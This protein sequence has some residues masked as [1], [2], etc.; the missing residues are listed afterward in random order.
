[1]FR[2]DTVEITGFW[3]NQTA[4]ARFFPDV[5]IFIGRNGTG[6]TTFMDLLHGVLTVDL[7]VLASH[8]F[9]S[10]SIRM[11]AGS[12]T[13]ILRVSKEQGQGPVELLRFQVGKN[14]YRFP[15]YSPE[16]DVHRHLRARP[17]LQAQFRTL[18]VALSKLVNVSSLPVDRS[19]HDSFSEDDYSPSRRPL[20]PQVDERLT[21]LS[22]QFTQYQLALASEA[23]GINEHFQNEVL[24]SIL[25]DPRFDSFATSNL[26]EID[27][28]HHE[29][30]LNKAYSE[31][32]A[33]TAEMPDRITKH[34]RAIERSLSAVRAFREDNAGIAIDDI[35]PIAL[36][37]RSTHIVQLLSDAEAQRNRVFR[38]ID[39]FLKTLR[40]FIS[41]KHLEVSLGGDLQFARGNREL[42]ISQLSSG[43]KQLLILLTETLLQR[44]QPFVFIADEPELSLHIEWQAQVV[45]SIKHLNE[46]AQVIVATHSPE[47][48]AGWRDR[49]IQMEE[50][51][52]G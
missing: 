42:S 8:E 15:L 47:I 23:E 5:S 37:R 13:R 52:S 20:R 1:M 12:R 6:K 43:E 50:V 29:E 27:L 45:K 44:S 9:D 30:E 24:A 40:S 26:K 3:G 21:D 31:L 19:A 49:I 7:R 41:D 48:A 18:K 38:P 25:Y 4:K 46:N 10:I 11:V 33:F 39:T 36:L 28:S 32:N 14:A 51:V 35:F 2:I 22:K 34:I 16:M 17:Q